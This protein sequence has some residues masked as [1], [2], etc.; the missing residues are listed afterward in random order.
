MEAG[1]I[2]N[3]DELQRGKNQINETLN[4][5]L[6]FVETN[7]NDWGYTISNKWSKHLIEIIDKIEQ[8]IIDIISKMGESIKEKYKLRENQGNQLS[9]LYGNISSIRNSFSQI[10]ANDSISFLKQF[11]I[12]S[13]ATGINTINENADSIF[14]YIDHMTFLSRVAE[15][16]PSTSKLYKNELDRTIQNL[17]DYLVELSGKIENQLITDFSNSVAEIE[18]FILNEQKETL[19]LDVLHN[20]I[21]SVKNNL[22]QINADNAV[23]LLE[24]FVDLSNKYSYV[25]IEKLKGITNT[26]NFIQK[27][28]AEK[29]SILHKITIRLN[30]LLN[31][32]GDASEW[33]YFLSNLMESTAPMTADSIRNNL[34]ILYQNCN[35]KEYEMINVNAFGLSEFLSQIK[36]KIDHKVQ[37]IRIN[38]FELK[39][40]KYILD[41]ITSDYDVSYAENTLTV[42][43]NTIKIS[44]V[45][46]MSN[47]TDAKTIELFALESIFFDH[48][49]NKAGEEVHLIIIA[50]R[51][52]IS[53]HIEIN[54][55]G[56]NGSV[57]Y[58]EAKS[59]VEPD[60]NGKSGEPGFA[61]TPGGFFFGIG[62]DFT[63]DT[64]SI[65]ANGG[66]GGAGQEGGDGKCPSN[67]KNERIKYYVYIHVFFIQ[68]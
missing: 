45:I 2:K 60:K 58:A 7:E 32:L 16:S 49:I 9:L 65:F 46:K 53:G 61:G 14:K 62:Q 52:D 55:N 68:A 17:D 10:N 41:D 37:D 8:N 54:L 30:V 50:P 12:K 57:Y 25:S 35:I 43:K 66:N 29:V 40:L 11:V 38:F 31:R 34:G 36:C 23:Q 5:Y 28:T 6:R 67:H 18:Q 24:K 27:I 33:Y 56:K 20:I 59:G 13:K 42:S 4:K 44:D 21:L 51:W 39:A 15:K 22:S 1:N 48:N 47:W 3:I 26:L 64:L 63:K 19:D